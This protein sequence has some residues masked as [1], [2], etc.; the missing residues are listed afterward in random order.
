MNIIENINKSRINL[1]KYLENEWDTSTIENYSNK[2]LELLY[3]NQKLLKENLISFGQGSNCNFS[4]QHRKIPSHNLHV[5]Y[6]NFPDYL[7]NNHVKITKTCA[8]KINGLYENEIIKKD[9]SV[10]IIILDKVSE[11]LSKSIENLYINGQEYLMN[12]NLSEDVIM[13]NESLIINERLSFKHFRNIHIFY[14]NH[15][16]IDISNNI[17]VPKHTVI[18]NQNDINKIFND[19]NCDE[20]KL[21]IILRTDPQAKIL[22]LAPGDICKIHRISDNVGDNIYYRICH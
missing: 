4:L 18:R 22:R 11:N 9:D 16:S 12:E 7:N 5:I 10:I 6:Y 1:K 21:P 8:D 2:E 19:C 13:E 14:L 3:N 15:L 17:Y 20:N